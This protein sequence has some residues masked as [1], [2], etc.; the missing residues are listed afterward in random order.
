MSPL[1]MLLPVLTAV[2]LAAAAQ[3]AGPGTGPGFGHGPGFAR[4][5][6]APLR[7]LTFE[8]RL[9]QR[10]ETRAVIQNMTFNQK[11]DWRKAQCDKFANSPPQEIQKYADGLK[12]KWDALSDAEKVQLYQQAHSFHRGAGRGMHQGFGGSK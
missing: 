2:F 9:I 6:C 3:A 10:R 11:R 5:D 8:E 4:G 1:R 7:G 12:A